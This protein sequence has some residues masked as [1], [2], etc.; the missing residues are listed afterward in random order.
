MELWVFVQYNVGEVRVSNFGVLS[1]NRE[2]VGE[3]LQSCIR[4]HGTN[5]RT[6]GVWM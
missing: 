4:E 5:F 1:E 6:K 3:M 2:L